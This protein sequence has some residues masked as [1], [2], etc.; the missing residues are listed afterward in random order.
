MPPLVLP[1]LPKN[2]PRFS[3]FRW[4]VPS[5]PLCP[6]DLWES[7]L[8]ILSFRTIASLRVPSMEV[9]YSSN[10]VTFTSNLSQ[11]CW[12]ASLMSTISLDHLSPSP[13]GVVCFGLDD[14]IPEQIGVPGP[15]YCFEQMI[16]GVLIQNDLVPSHVV[17]GASSADRNPARGGPT[18]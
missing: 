16:V 4:Q 1:P 7:V 8:Q 13:G 11:K 12:G 3:H 18:V 17:Y 14:G 10:L 2:P 6:V 5:A 15:F 9:K